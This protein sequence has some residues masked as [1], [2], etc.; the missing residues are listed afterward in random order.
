MPRS[1]SVSL[2][3]RGSTDIS[4]IESQRRSRTSS[5]H[6]SPRLR[7]ASNSGEGQDLWL[8]SGRDE[9]AFYQAE[10]QMMTREN[11]MLK[12]RIRELGER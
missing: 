6:A 12:Q 9:N 8:N 5:Q 11:Q 3:H 7:A 2:R 10:A 1:P 4:R